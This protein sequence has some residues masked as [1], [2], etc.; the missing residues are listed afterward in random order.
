MQNRFLLESTHQHQSALFLWTDF[1]QAFA[2]SLWGFYDQRRLLLDQ[3][4]EIASI[5]QL[6]YLLDKNVND[7]CPFTVMGMFNRGVATEKRIK[8]AQALADFLNVQVAVPQCF[9]GIPI[10]NNQKSWFFGDVE[11]RAEQDI[12]HLWQLFGCALAYAK[13]HQS[14]ILTAQF[15]QLYDQVSGQY[16]VG[17]N[18]S[19]G[20][21][22]LAPYH[23]MSLD[24][25]SQTYIEHDLALK[26]SHTGAK[27]RCSGAQYINLL[28]HMQRSFQE[29][30][31]LANSFPAVALLAWEQQEALKSLVNDNDD[32]LEHVT[33]Q[34]QEDLLLP[35]TL[36]HI[37]AEGCFLEPTFLEHALQ[38]LEDKKNLI[39][40]GSAGTGKTWLAQRLA[41]A[42]I[43]HQHED[44]RCTVQFHANTSYE[45]FIRGWR[46]ELNPQTQKHEL[47]LVDGIFL[48]FVQKAQAEPNEKF[49]FIIEEINRGQPAHIFGELLTLL[50]SSKRSEANALTLIYTREKEK[51][52]LPANLYLIAT[53][54]MSDRSLVSLDLALRRRFAF[55]TLRPLLN[56]AWLAYVVQKNIS[57]QFA[58]KIQQKIHALNQVIQ[59]DPQL[60]QYYMIGHSFFTPYTHIEQQ[61]LWYQQIIETEIAP[62]L[63]EYWFD[64]PDEVEIQLQALRWMN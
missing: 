44:Q 63:E 55:L 5:Y 52:F 24:S 6:S 41:Q 37:V 60:G 12:E 32:D 53:M 29:R 46:P 17:W 47:S 30:K 13:A 43:G 33:Q 2:Q 3:V 14:E 23:F 48:K 42:L 45:D 62:L 1:Y 56:Q 10:L 21:F 4:F 25:Q 59:Q 57:R 35:Y 11:H 58:E 64:R 15:I 39:L 16:G 20:L 28:Q 51:I 36:Q 40:Q 38:R 31:N 50:E 7:I 9:D 34:L 61:E 27:R 19:M 54:N 18:L 8:I 22:W 26:I 49:V